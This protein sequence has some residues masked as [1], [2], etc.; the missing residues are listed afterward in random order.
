MT[1]NLVKVGDEDTEGIAVGVFVGFDVGD[2]VGAAKYQK[3]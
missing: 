2:L 3:M 1:A